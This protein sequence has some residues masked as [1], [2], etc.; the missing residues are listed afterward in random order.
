VPDDVGHL[1]DVGPETDVAGAGSEA[2][3]P[4]L[5]QNDLQE[6]KTKTGFARGR[7]YNHNFLRFLTIFGKKS[8]FFSKT[9]VMLIFFQRKYLKNHNIGPGF[10]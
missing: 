8:A 4:A 2:S 5:R 6:T 1:L 7:C 9:N 3:A 10:F